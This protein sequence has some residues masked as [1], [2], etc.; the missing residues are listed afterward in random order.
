MC[1]SNNNTNNENANALHRVPNSLST[2][3][4]S[5]GRRS[6]SSRSSV[7][8]RQPAYHPVDCVTLSHLTLPRMV[9]DSVQDGCGGSNA[10]EDGSYYTLPYPRCCNL[11]IERSELIKII[12]D[13]LAL[14]S[15][16]DDLPFAPSSEL[17]SSKQWLEREEEKD[18]RKLKSSSDHLPHHR[19]HHTQVQR[20]ERWRWYASLHFTPCGAV[21]TRKT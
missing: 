17:H 4:T 10:Y 7:E 14:L 3:N 9:I 18:K 2:N 12:D 16:E 21:I 11:T 6:I 19:H 1:L 13:V 15:D 8:Y 20:K 5:S